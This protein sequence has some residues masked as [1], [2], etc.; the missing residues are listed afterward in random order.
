MDGVGR[1]TCKHCGTWWFGDDPR[2]P[3]CGRMVVE[4]CITFEESKGCPWGTPFRGDHEHAEL[5]D[6]VWV[7]VDLT[8]KDIDSSETNAIEQDAASLDRLFGWLV[9][10]GAK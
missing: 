7:W 1:E 4:V 2:C 8:K 10:T 9:R 3:D 6:D 5:H